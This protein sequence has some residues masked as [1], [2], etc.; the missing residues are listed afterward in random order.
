MAAP[1]W[2]KYKIT[3]RNR[4]NL[5]K[6]Y[7]VCHVNIGLKILNDK[8]IAAGL[9]YDKS[10]LNKTRTLVCWI[11]PNDWK[12]GYRYGNVRFAF[13]WNKIYR[14]MNSYWVE[15]MDYTPPALR[16]LLSDQDHSK[17]LKPYDP[18]EDDGP[19]RY[20]PKKNRHYWNHNYCLEI[21][22]ER[23]IRLSEVEKIDF[24]NHHS[25]YC[26]LPGNCDEMGQNKFDGAAYF[27][28]GMVGNDIDCHRRTPKFYKKE[29][30]EYL[31]DYSFLDGCELILNEFELECSGTISSTDE[32]AKP[33]ARAILGSFAREDAEF[34]SLAKLFKSRK[35]LIKSCTKLIADHF[36]IQD[37]K[38]LLP[39]TARRSRRRKKL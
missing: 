28:A 32:V 14:E 36:N 26:C 16:I 15:V 13:D 7:H 5:D 10:R 20:N 30:D 23:D 29:D 31:V 39:E 21:M 12:D 27:I 24:V 6:I 37:W 22:V 25:R 4:G 11:S 8:R 2:E 18:V 35:A 19:W 3:S 9:V 38:Q 1:E 34:E 17:K 33:L